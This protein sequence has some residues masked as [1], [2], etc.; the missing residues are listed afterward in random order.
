MI[1]SIAGCTG[2]G[3]VSGQ[4]LSTFIDRTKGFDIEAA[5]GK[6]IDTSHFVLMDTLPSSMFIPDRAEIIIYDAAAGGA[7]TDPTWAISAYNTQ[8]NGAGSEVTSASPAA[9]TPRMF[10]GYV[11]TPEYS[12]DDGA[13]RY[14]NVA[15][16]DYTTRLRT[17]VTNMAFAAGGTDQTMIKQLFARYRPDYNTANISLILSAFPAVTYPVHTLEQCLERIIKVTRGYYRADYYKQM[18]YGIVGQQ[19]APFN[20]SDVPNYTTTFPTEGISYTPDG[21]GLANRVWVLGSTYLSQVQAY[22]VPPALVNGANFQFP[23]PGN[24]EATGMTITVA[25]AGQGTIGIAPAD[26]DVTTPSGFKYN[27][28]IQHSPATVSFKTPPG[29][30]QAVIITGQFRYPLVQVVTD[31]TLIA[32][33]NGIIFEAIIRDKR[34]ND[35]S[36]AKQVGLA[37]LKNQGSTLKGGTCTIRT[38][39]VGG[40]LLQP[41]H[42]ITIKNDVLFRNVVKD[43]NGNPTT[44]AVV[45]VTQLRT[46]LDDDSIQ[47]YKIEVSFA[48][49]NVSGG[50]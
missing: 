25:G 12:A 39:Q 6:R 40:I 7:V 30:G 46:Q 19:T 16:Q 43:A 29:S 31:A 37:F 15:C 47:P 32:A 21:S 49:R 11:A 48:D 28:L 24:P 3:I 26:G 27:T 42:V 50:Y 35:A 33:T 9:W 41:G 2:T 17:T 22:Q 34:I 1:L 10:G 13:Q 44:T 18:W 4:D 45:I 20:L 8:R 23:L 36:L 14:I 5:I 38:R